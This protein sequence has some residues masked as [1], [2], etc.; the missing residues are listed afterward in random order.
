MSTICSADGCKELC[1]G[2]LGENL[3]DLGVDAN[4]HR[5]LKCQ[6]SA[7]QSAAGKTR[8]SALPPTLPSAAAHEERHGVGPRPI[9]QP[10]ALRS[11]ARPTT[12][13]R[14]SGHPPTDRP[15]AAQEHRAA[16]RPARSRQAAPRCAAEPA[17]DSS[18]S[19][20][21]CCTPAAGS[22][23]FVV[24]LALHSSSPG[25]PRSPVGR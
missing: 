6:R 2:V 7:R 19:R 9:E 21:K 13:R 4:E 10:W 24:L 14:I 1:P 5:K 16:E 17:G 8:R 11:P 12:C 23:G 22:G 18:S 25:H 15:S 3:E 20:K